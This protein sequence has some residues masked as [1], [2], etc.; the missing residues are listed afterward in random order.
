MNSHSN[1]FFVI[2]HIFCS[3]VRDCGLD[4][5][6]GFEEEANV[7]FLFKDSGFSQ[8]RSARWDRGDKN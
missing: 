5:D 4:L 8:R 3:T 7:S 1:T 2:L 6:F